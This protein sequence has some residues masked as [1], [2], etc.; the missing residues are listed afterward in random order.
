[1]GKQHVNAAVKFPVFAI[2]D[3][4]IEVRSADE[5]K[6]KDDAPQKVLLNVGGGGAARSGVGNFIT[7]FALEHNEQNDPC[8]KQRFA[9]NTGLRLCTTVDVAPNMELVASSLEGGCLMLR[10]D[11]E[12]RELQEIG[13]F[14]TD[15][16]IDDSTPP[17]QN[18]ARFCPTDSTL[19]ATGGDD[20]T[21]GL[22]KVTVTAKVQE[23]ERGEDTADS[24]KAPASAKIEE[25]GVELQH[26]PGTDEPSKEKEQDQQPDASADDAAQ[27]TST[28]PPTPV[29]E[30]ESETPATETDE[31]EAAASEEE[32]EGSAYT[33]SVERKLNLVGHSKGI[34][35][36]HFSPSGK[37][38]VTASGDNTCRIWN[39]ADGKVLQIIPSDQAAGMVFRRCRFLTDDRLLTLQA[40]PGRGGNS[41]IVEF[42]RDASASSPR[43]WVLR[44]SARVLKGLATTMHV[45]P[46]MISV[47]DAAGG[48]TLHD[49]ESLRNLAHMDEVH[50]LPVTGLSAL[51]NPADSSK[52]YVVT[53]SMDKTMAM[54]PGEAARVS[55]FMRILVPLLLVLLVIFVRVALFSDS[56]DVDGSHSEL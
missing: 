39:V 27:D 49:F 32:D 11:K 23:K 56:A 45:H 31:K 41:F 16:P 55:W 1:M 43:Q 37:L 48:L 12:A 25:K 35:D 15:V 19:L 26:G 42:V 44:K 54:I 4:A 29:P 36:L 8:I 14:D 47:A 3:G 50:S 17:C 38:L 52:H 6:N 13:F 24:P 40:K 33:L 9:F 21:A 18:V 53:G 34:K 46:P 20:T 7:G 22:W 10:Y 2:S 5:E 30:T 28:E 51:P